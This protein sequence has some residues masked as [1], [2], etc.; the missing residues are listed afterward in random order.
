[1]RTEH[2]VAAH[3]IRWALEYYANL[4]LSPEQ[5]EELVGILQRTYTDEVIERIRQKEEVLK[6]H[7]REEGRIYFSTAFDPATVDEPGEEK[8]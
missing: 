4:Q 1:M 7:G 5:S 3:A 2:K 8:S 6:L